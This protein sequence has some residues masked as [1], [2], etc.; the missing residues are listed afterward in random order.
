[1]DETLNL[2]AAIIGAGIVTYAIRLSFILAMERL[3]MPDWFRNALRFAPAAVLSA[4]VLP[5][6]FAGVT[7]SAPVNPQLIAGA[8]AILVAWRT[9]NVLLT[10]LAGMAVFLLLQQGLGWS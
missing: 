10:V 9:R 3:T 2:W 5:A 1:M 6:L 7:P 8:C 4:I